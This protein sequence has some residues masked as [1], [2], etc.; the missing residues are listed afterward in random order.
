MAV[1]LPV[2]SSRGRRRR[3][4]AGWFVQSPQ[5]EAEPPS[6][7]PGRAG[8]FGTVG[9]T[10]PN[11]TGCPP[12]RA[13]LT[14]TD[15]GERPLQPATDLWSHRVFDEVSASWEVSLF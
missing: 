7:P 9:S 15:K 6:R 2:S 11:R 8:H 3:K 5:F 13:E 14:P 10:V 12:L 4:G 1:S